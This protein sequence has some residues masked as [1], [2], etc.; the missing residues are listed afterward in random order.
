MSSVIPLT[1]LDAVNLILADIGDRPVNTLATT[2]RLDVTRAVDTLDSVVRQLCTLGWWFCEEAVDVVV[3]NSGHYNIPNDWTK[4]SYTSGGPTTGVRGAPQYTVRGRR[5]YD[6]VNATDTFDATS[7]TIN[8]SISRLL[9]FEDL[10]QA[11]RE[12]AY[13][14]AS[15]T[16]QSR[17][18]GSR[19]VDGDLRL[20]AA[21]ALVTLKTEEVDVSVEDTTYSPRFIELMHRR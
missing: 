21:Q 3:D 16:M 2:N 10:P 11:A 14:T 7:P 13:A 12:Y 1:K 15:V 4:V 17:T 5:L 9:E 18:L 19:Q 20:R 8:L 6:V